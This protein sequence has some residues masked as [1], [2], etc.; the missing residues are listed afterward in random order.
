VL[1]NRLGAV[2]QCSSTVQLYIVLQDARVAAE[3]PGGRAGLPGGRAGL[4]GAGARPAGL[5]QGQEG[6]HLGGGQ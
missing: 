3:L 6:P 5:R 4:P 2:I 1:Q